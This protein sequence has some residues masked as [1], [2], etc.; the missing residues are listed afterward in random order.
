MM[1]VSCDSN[2]K[3]STVV[4]FP[5]CSPDVSDVP[6]TFDHVKPMKR[7]FCLTLRGVSDQGTKCPTSSAKRSELTVRGAWVQWVTAVPWIDWLKGTIYY[8]LPR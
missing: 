1:F 4:S 2:P 7:S 3:V 6:I 8:N 5:C